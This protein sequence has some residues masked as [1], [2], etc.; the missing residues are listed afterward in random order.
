MSRVILPR[1]LLSDPQAMA[2]A[3]TNQLNATALAIQADF[4]VTTQTWKDKPEFTITSPSPYERVIG[5]S[6]AIYAMLN[7][8]TPPHPISAHSGVLRFS[9][10]FQSKTLPHSI[11]SGPGSRG[12]SEVYRRTVQ[13]P[14]TE[15]REWDTTI[16]EKWDRE[17]ATQMQRAIDA[18]VS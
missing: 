4:K 9:A 16:A 2:R 1:R 10:P 12:G 6:D 15:P 11:S 3:I 8:G 18:A 7:A 17:A 5:T 14:G 13:H